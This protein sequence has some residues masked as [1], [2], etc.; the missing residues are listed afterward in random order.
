MYVANHKHLAWLPSRLL[1]EIVL[2][3]LLITLPSKRYLLLALASG[4]TELLNPIKSAFARF[5]ST[6]FSTDKFRAFNLHS[7]LL[8][9]CVG[10]LRG[11]HT[12]RAEHFRWHHV[13]VSIHSRFVA[14]RF[15]CYFVIICTIKLSKLGI[16][17][18]SFL[19]LKKE[20]NKN[21]NKTRKQNIQSTNQSVNQLINNWS[22]S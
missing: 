12:G 7:S 21:K 3:P 2:H 15:L 10:R 8:H 16:D 22:C 18:I 11:V 17:K 6:Q 4:Q 19:S 13:N 9:I 14:G 20:K 1:K 5:L